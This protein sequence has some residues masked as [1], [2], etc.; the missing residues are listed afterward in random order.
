MPAPQAHT[1]NGALITH[2]ERTTQTHAAI[3]NQIFAPETQTKNL[4]EESAP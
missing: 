2:H 4:K 1:I 3:A